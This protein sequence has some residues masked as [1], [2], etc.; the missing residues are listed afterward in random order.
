[1]PRGKKIHL[2]VGTYKG[3]FLFISDRLRK[4]WSVKGPFLKG[5]EVNDII[6]DTRADATLFACANSAWFGAGVRISRDLGKTWSEPEGGIRFEE[7]SD[8]KVARVWTIKPG[9][10]EASSVLYAGVDPGALFKSEDGGAGWTEI[11]GLS[12]HPTRQKW[13]PGAGG[14]MVHSICVDTQNPRR[15]FVGI[16]AAGVFSTD[17]SGSS[18]EA[19]NKGVLADFLPDKY[20]EVGQ[21]VHHLEMSPGNADLFYQQNHCGV[22]RTD[23]GGRTWVDIS[24]GLPS[25][26]GFPI[27]VHPH[28]ADT[29]YVIPEEGAE[30]RAVSNASFGIYR[31]RNKG[32]SWK[33]LSKGLPAK[34]AYSHVYRQATTA[35]SLERTGLYVG[36]SN[37]QIFYSLN[38][39]D[40]WK[41]LAENLPPVYSLNVSVR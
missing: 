24:K 22:Y 16:S 31:S 29:V 36:T 9:A 27:I 11:Q 32:K 17:D 41:L 18:W 23:D 6:L 33:K 2:L 30:F 1:M 25:R 15:M 20:P 8:R 3:A 10:D 35:D 26:F 14:M 21:C 4:N 37:G 13:Q 38:D 39:G 5:L 7:G 28:D 40:S 12:N 19:R 34:H